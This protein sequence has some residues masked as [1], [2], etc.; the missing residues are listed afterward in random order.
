MQNLKNSSLGF[1]LME[2][3]VEA[4]SVKQPDDSDAKQTY[5]D[6]GV[7]FCDLHYATNKL[8]GRELPQYRQKNVFLC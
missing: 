1:V 2:T 8:N 4:H 3:K 5:L 6:S 7:T